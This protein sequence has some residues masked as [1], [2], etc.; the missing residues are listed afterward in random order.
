MLAVAA[1]HACA[2]RESEPK[3]ARTAVVV[4]SAV[5]EASQE[6]A[7]APDAAP[8]S[9]GRSLAECRA[10][11]D[12]NTEEAKQEFKAGVEAMVKDDAAT[13]AEI[14]LRSYERTCNA[15]LLYNLG[16]VREKLGDF[17]GAAE[18]LEEYLARQPASFRVDEVKR[19]IQEL[20]ART[21]R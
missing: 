12:A 9:R 5:A 16:V 21:E 3:P 1:A 15:A 8:R 11:A 4:P 2:T 10:P 14:F 19:R 17:A 18:A 20:R 6:E 7:A 13:A